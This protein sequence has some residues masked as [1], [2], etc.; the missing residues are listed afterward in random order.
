MLV[1]RT[2]RISGNW[3]L[4]R[5]LAA[6]KVSNC[7]NSVKLNR[8]QRKIEIYLSVNAA[9]AEKIIKMFQGQIL[10]DNNNC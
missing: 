6:N 9:K 8:L 2:V 10:K 1:I 3:Y 4:V 7:W 5:Y